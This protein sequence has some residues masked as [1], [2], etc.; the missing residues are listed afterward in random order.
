MEVTSQSG[1]NEVSENLIDDDFDMHAALVHWSKLL[2]QLKK[3]KDEEMQLRKKLFGS[4]F[5]DPDE[6]V[7]DFDLGNGWTL[8]GT[9]KLSRKIDEPALAAILKKMPKTQQAKLIVNKPSLVKKIYDKLTDK[10]RS[11][12]DQALIIKPGSPTLVIVPPKEK[13]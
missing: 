5:E 1:I 13:E 10:N 9:Y 2:P 3:I 6:G 11:V 12:F 7:N 4:F 8:K